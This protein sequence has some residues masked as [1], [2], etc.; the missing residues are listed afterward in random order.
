MGV[1][2]KDIEPYHIK[3]GIPART[4]KIKTIA[5]EAVRKASEKA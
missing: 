4:L 2:T 5:P 1:A 3:G